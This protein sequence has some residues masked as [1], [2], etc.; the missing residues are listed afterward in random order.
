MAIC[1]KCDQAATFDSP[2]NLCD[3]HWAEWWV[4]GLKPKSEEE[5]EQLLKETLTEIGEAT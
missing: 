4:D 2:D 3:Q 5:R 1:V